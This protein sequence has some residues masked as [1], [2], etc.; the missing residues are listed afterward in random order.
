LPE[1]QAKHKTQS[2]SMPFKN[3]ETRKKYQ[4]EWYKNKCL[5]LPTRKPNKINII[6]DP[7]KFKAIKRE[8]CKRSRKK[9]E[10]REKEQIGQLIG[11]K[12]CLC[13]SE[14][15]IT[16]HR[17]NGI[18][19]S[20]NSNAEQRRKDVLAHPEEFV[21]VCYGCHKGIHWVMKWFNMSWEEILQEIE[22]HKKQMQV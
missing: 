7:E 15:R 6:Q 16:S 18:P 17:K 4:R 3:I 10:L 2:D 21:R 20:P 14:R 5:G 9:L 12:C 1:K 8:R 19:H 22:K 11:F 13:G